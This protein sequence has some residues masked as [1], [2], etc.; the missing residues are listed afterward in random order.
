[1][2]VPVGCAAYVKFIR[3][4][5]RKKEGERVARPQFHISIS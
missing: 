5:F 3:E 4:V 2:S 1:M